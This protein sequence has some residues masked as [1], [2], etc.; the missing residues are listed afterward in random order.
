MPDSVRLCSSSA[1]M[2]AEVTSM[3]VTGS[4][5]TIIR[6]TG[7]GDSANGFEESPVKELGVSEKERRVPTKQHESWNATR[8]RIPRDVV[9]AAN[10]IDSAEHCEVW[11]P[12]IPQELD[13]RD[14]DCDSDAGNHA[15]HGNAHKTDHR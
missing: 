15:E 3:L 14:H 11:P 4:A 7:V 9:V 1:S 8:S 12:G 13:H 6:R 10:T 2:S 5:V